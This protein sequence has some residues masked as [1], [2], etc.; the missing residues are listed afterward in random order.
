MKYKPLF[1]PENFFISIKT[2]FNLCLSHAHIYTEIRFC[3]LL[4]IIIFI[5]TQYIF[6][7]LNS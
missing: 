1:Q 6:F 7:L 3:N 4:I 5:S 2:K